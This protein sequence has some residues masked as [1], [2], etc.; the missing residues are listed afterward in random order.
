[1]QV[2]KLK[3]PK[4]CPLQ[5]GDPE[6]T[7]V[8]V[9]SKSN[10]LR[11]RRTDDVGSSLSPKGGEN[12]CPSSKTVRQREQ[13]LPSSVFCSIQISKDWRPTQLGRGHLPY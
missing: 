10:G 13:I 1:M 2:R 6:E 11:I 7:I 4:V 9:Q 12:Q 5:A 8:R 3:S